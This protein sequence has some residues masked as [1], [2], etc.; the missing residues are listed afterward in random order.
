MEHIKQN[1]AAAPGIIL[2]ILSLLALPIF[3]A[4]RCI[5]NS[6][7]GR[8]RSEGIMCVNPENFSG[9]SRSQV[10]IV[11]VLLAIVLVGI[12]LCCLIGFIGNQSLN[13]GIT[14]M[15]NSLL[16]T[17]TEIYN[18]TNNIGIQLQL[19]PYTAS[20]GEQLQG[21][22]NSSSTYITEGN[23][24]KTQI[25]KYNNYRTIAIAIS[26]AFPLG[27]LVIGTIAA[28]FNL[29]YVSF[30]AAMFCFICSILIWLSFGVHYLT[31]V[32]IGDVCVEINVYF[33]EFTNNQ[34]FS[35]SS[36]PL[37]V[38]I[39]C[40]NGDNVFEPIENI[41]L[42]ALNNSIQEY[43]NTINTVCSDNHVNCSANLEGSNCTINN[44]IKFEN[45]SVTDYLLA[46]SDDNECIFD[47]DTVNCSIT[48][49][50]VCYAKTVD[51]E[52][53]S[54]ACNNSEL[55][56]Y[57]SIAVYNLHLLEKYENILFNEIFP[58]LNC[59]FVATAFNEVDD[60]LCI[61]VKSGIDRIA[62]S[63]GILG[64]FLVPGTILLIIGFKRFRSDREADLHDI[65]MEGY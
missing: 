53:C 25:S 44:I 1:I 57:T 14:T 20:Y 59:S 51:V 15:E 4:L 22:V 62:I 46:C 10:I 47:A 42:G 21:Y 24:V 30:A 35:T 45:H 38:L 63:S 34:S 9:Y 5:C 65:D 56:N 17:A 52:T 41:A 12:F 6:V 7:G 26:Y 27:L 32:V 2:A 23:N 31:Q 49:Q 28:I 60:S 58:L 43:C 8:K 64:A 50:Y 33:Q 3:L 39:S 48:E 40:K 11:K 54:T 55:R 13:R 37:D 16:D 29:K 36:S 18:K 61:D 19:L